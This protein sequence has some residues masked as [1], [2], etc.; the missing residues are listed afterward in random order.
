MKQRLKTFLAGTTVVAGTFFGGCASQKDMNDVI[1]VVNA[2]TDKNKL[3]AIQQETTDLKFELVE[4]RL[5]AHEQR[6]NDQAQYIKDILPMIEGL[7]DRQGK[8]INEMAANTA[9]REK[10][11]QSAAQA[12]ERFQQI[13]REY[14]ERNQGQELPAPAQP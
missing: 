9:F 8:M 3:T 14:A 4:K 6:L 5:A 1:G 11:Q 13:D 7:A 2:H 10:M 12:V